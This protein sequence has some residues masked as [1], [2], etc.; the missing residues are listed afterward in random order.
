M[1]HHD[2]D[3]AGASHG[4]YKSYIIGFVISIIL[5]LIPFALVMQGSLPKSSILFWIS[6]AALVQIVVQLWFFLHLNTS[7]E[8]RWNLLAF[9]LTVLITI[10]LVGGSLW[11]MHNLEIRMMDMDHGQPAHELHQH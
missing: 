5:T 4:T 10:L 7:S 2:S 11:I 9:A 8:Q 1:E 6:F 3:H